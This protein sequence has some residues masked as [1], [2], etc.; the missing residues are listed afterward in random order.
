MCKRHGY[1]F[2]G[3]INMK[4]NKCVKSSI[5]AEVRKMQTSNPPDLQQQDKEKHGNSKFC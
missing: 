3:R 2:N 5:S 4:A 1:T